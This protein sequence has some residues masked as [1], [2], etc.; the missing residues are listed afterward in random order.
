MVV[1]E[2]LR[3]RRTELGLTQAIVAN[4]AGMSTVQYNGYER[5][6]HEPT[7]KTLARLAKAL[8]TM[9]DDLADD[10]GAP[11]D[12]GGAEAL[13]DALRRRVAQDANWSFD[14]VR[15]LVQLE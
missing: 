9:A 11:S 10:G 6:R 8:R 13:K 15:V 7:E 5:G 4:R 3:K 12:L 2:K 14:R 1:A